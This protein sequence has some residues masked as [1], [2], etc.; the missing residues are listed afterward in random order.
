MSKKNGGRQA[1]VTGLGI[2]SPIGIGSDEF[3][4]KAIAGRSG[5]GL[6]TQFDTSNLPRP[7]QIAG[8]VRDFVTKDWMGGIA[9]RMAARFSQFATATCKMAIQDGRLDH[10]EVPSERIKVSFGSSMSGVVDFQESSFSAFLRGEEVVPWTLLEF[11]IHAATSHVSAESGARGHPVSFATACCA[12][13]DAIGWAADQIKSGRATAV[14]AGAAD[15]PLSPF[16]LA[17]FHSAKTI[18]T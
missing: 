2:V 11:P 12:G 18:S 13:L 8:E 10:A 7:C 15:A 14:I 5:I 4:K 16:V 1:V 6:V 9:G 3:W 17:T